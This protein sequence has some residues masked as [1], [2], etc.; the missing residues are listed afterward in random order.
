MKGGDNK[1]ALYEDL[2]AFLARVLVGARPPPR[3]MMCQL[4]RSLYNSFDDPRDP[5][6]NQNHQAM[7][8]RTTKGEC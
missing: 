6:F 3:R 1:M 2:L 8:C 5:I 4:A 7:R